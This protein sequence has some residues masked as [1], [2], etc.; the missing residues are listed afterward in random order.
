MASRWGSVRAI[1]QRNTELRA[2]QR[3]HQLE[4]WEDGKRNV[5]KDTCSEALIHTMLDPLQASLP[6]SKY[7]GTVDRFIKPR[8]VS[9]LGPQAK[10]TGKSTSCLPWGKP[11]PQNH[12]CPVRPRQVPPSPSGT[13]LGRAGLSVCT[14]T[15]GALEDEKEKE[16][17][18]RSPSR[19][20]TVASLV[21]E[22][23]GAGSF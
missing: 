11:R 19:A 23:T 15:S 6:D 2:E 9:H 18:S 10:P 1:A 17:G 22:F 16:R 20:S 3:T 5:K 14:S 4:A 21:D 8:A 13:M 12:C 7:A